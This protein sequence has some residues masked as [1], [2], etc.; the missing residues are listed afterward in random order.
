MVAA[1]V[2]SITIKAPH[3]HPVIR[4]A[5]N[6][7]YRD[8]PVGFAA[9][10]VARKYPGASFL[11]IGANIGD[12]AAM[13]ASYAPNPLILVEASTIYQN[14]LRQNAAM[15]PNVRRVEFV[16]V[17]SDATPP[18]GRLRHWGG[19]AT[20]E[21]SDEQAIGS[22]KRLADV[23]DVDTKFIKIDTD[24]FDFAILRSS[25]DWLTLAQPLVLFESDVP[26]HDLHRQGLETLNALVAI[27]YRWFVVWDDRG[28]HMTTT[29]DIGVLRDLHT[30][31]HTRRQAASSLQ[32]VSNF[33]ILC[34]VGS[35]RD[36]VDAVTNAYLTM[37]S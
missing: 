7:P 16:F 5:I 1:T 27:G 10:A 30:W 33:D 34:A 37:T 13:M 25:V 20:F 3:R 4:F 36:V 29:D 18:S 11:D 26:T 9:E 22:A 6:Q 23:A 15:L 14:I 12:T 31:L 21:A 8:L 17:S 2:G 24:G 35:D 32:G 19:T 28:Y